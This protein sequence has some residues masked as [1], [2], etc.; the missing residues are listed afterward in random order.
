[1]RVEYY[2]ER[3]PFWS[4]DGDKNFIGMPHVYVYA[5]RPEK[6]CCEMMKEKW[7]KEIGFCSGQNGDFAYTA[8]PYLFW[9]LDHKNDIFPL[10]LEEYGHKDEKVNKCP[11]CHASIKF[12]KVERAKEK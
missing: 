10:F 6:F 1:M 9:T 2:F 12:K 7:Q 8:N 11:F 4:H 3:D 5:N